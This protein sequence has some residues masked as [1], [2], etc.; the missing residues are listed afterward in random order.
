MIKLDEEYR[1]ESDGMSFKLVRKYKPEKAPIKG[2]AREY[3]E[4]VIGYYT[5]LTHAVNRWRRQVVM[6]WAEHEKLNLTQLV[7][8]INDFDSKLMDKLKR[9]DG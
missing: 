2:K 7:D 1:I 5:S 9:L 8:R 3:S 6:S 4:D